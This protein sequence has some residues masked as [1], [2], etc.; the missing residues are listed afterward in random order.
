LVKVRDTTYFFPHRDRPRPYGR[1]R[2]RRIPRTDPAERQRV[3]ALHAAHDDM[4]P[5][6]YDSDHF[7]GDSTTPSMAMNRLPLT[8]RM[9]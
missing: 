3:R 6:Q 2:P 4:S 7:S 8:F 1:A 9:R 5:F